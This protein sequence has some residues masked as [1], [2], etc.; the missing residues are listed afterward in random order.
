MY[1]TFSKDYFADTFI[2]R[3]GETGA[4]FLYTC[5]ASILAQQFHCLVRARLAAMRMPPSTLLGHRQQYTKSTTDHS[6]CLNGLHQQPRY[7][8]STVNRVYTT[9]YGASLCSSVYTVRVSSLDVSC[10]ASSRAIL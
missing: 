4:I 8:F 3:A 7:A 5:F 1:Y 6:L 2:G 10:C 9:W